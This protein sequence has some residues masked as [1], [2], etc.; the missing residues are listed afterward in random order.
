MIGIDIGGANL[1]V[2][3][4][5]G[6]HIHYCPLWKETSVREIL[7]EYSSADNA[8]VVMSGELADCFS[9]KQE[10]I[11]FL[12]DAVRNVFPNAKFY[13]IDGK[14]H[15][16]PVSQIA[17]ANWLV[18]A[19]VLR[20]KYPDCLLVDMGSTTTDIIPLNAWEILKEQ[21]DFIRLKTGML[22]Y[23][24]LLRT[25]VSSLIRRVSP[26]GNDILLSTEYFACSGD[27]HLLMEM[28]TSD[29]YTTATPD[30]C[31]TS[32]DHC[33][34]RM[35]RMV[36]AD[37]HEVGE[38]LVLQ[39]ARE[40]VNEEIKLITN[41]VSPIMKKYGCV[42]ILTVGI[43]SKLLASCLN[44]HDLASEMGTL[45]DAMPA[46]AVREAGLRIV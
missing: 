17:A 37:V 21:T 7:Q 4:E 24:G 32:W 26:D 27:A 10:G 44:A 46:W 31:S 6:A 13:G 2:V 16:K 45:S 43:G 18:M 40:Y 34:R 15:T 38:D 9:S 39:I 33:L 41:A 25:P 3:D 30:S 35:A 8:A 29:M 23:Y 20:F 19:D 11:N 22:L 5:H 42:R 1:K 12:Y 36:C 14:F 28:I